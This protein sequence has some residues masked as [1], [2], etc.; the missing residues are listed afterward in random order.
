LYARQPQLA[1]AVAAD[2]GIPAEDLGGLFP[3][4]DWKELTAEF[5]L[6]A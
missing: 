4:T 5:F 1:G 2:G 6:T 3:D